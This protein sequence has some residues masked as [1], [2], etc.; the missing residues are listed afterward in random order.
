MNTSKLL[1]ASLLGLGLAL[2]CLWML[3]DP[4]PIARAA[5]YQVINTYASGT[6]SLRWAINGANSNQPVHDTITF[7][8]SVSGTIVL[9]STLPEVTD[10]LTITGPGAIT[11]AISGD[12][13]YRVFEIASGTAVTISDV[14][15]RDGHHASLGGG[16]YSEGTLFLIDTDIVSNTSDHS[17][18]GLC[19][20]AGVATL[21][22]G[23]VISNA[24]AIN[25]G[26]IRS[27]GTLLL[28]GADVVSNTAGTPSTSGFG[29]GVYVLG[30]GGAFTQTDDS[31]VGYNTADNGGGVYVFQ[32]SATLSGGQIVS[33]TAL[34]GGG[35]YVYKPSGAFTQTGASTVTLNHAYYDG[36]GMYVNQG[37]A[38][39][40]GGSII[41]NSA[42]DDGGAVY[43]D[44]GDVTLGGGQIAHNTADDLGGGVFV[45]R[46]DAVFTQTGG[47]AIAC[48][49]AQGGGGVYVYRGSAILSG[50][51]LSNTAKNGSSGGGGILNG[52]GSATLSGARVVSN[53]ALGRGGG[54]YSVSTLTLTNTTV[55]HNR[56]ATG[57]GGGIFVAGGASLSGGEV[58]NNSAGDDGGGV[59]IES[60][61]VTLNGTRVLSNTA[62]SDGGGVYNG[63]ALNVID[64][65][66]RGN[67][68]DAFQS[69]GG[70]IYNQGALTVS[71][72]AFYSNSATSEFSYGG[73][74]CN[75]SGTT[76]IVNCMFSGNYAA[77]D[78]M[79]MGGG[80]YNQGGTTVMTFTTVVSNTASG[81][82]G[83]IN[84]TS[85]AVFAKNTLVAHNDATGTTADDCGGSALNS[86]GHNLD[87]DDTCG[88]TATSDITST[89]PL[90]GPLTYDSGTWVHPLLEGS[91]A[92]N[93][94]ECVPNVTT[95]DQRGVTRPEGGKCDIGAYEWILPYKV[96][97]P[98]VLRN[99]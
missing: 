79:G 70:G 29:G 81:A 21:T 22:G 88:L 56:A 8:P 15:I 17:G 18:G 24:A 62:E 20:N 13:I 44:S 92:I 35:V 38:T 30:P 58:S 71:G 6:G 51:I 78:T 9:T 48:N 72:S 74:I 76:T 95:V 1:A 64:T 99:Y 16:I 47:A 65:L 90:L 66:F 11:L 3:N 60:G 43:V 14:T 73:G 31:T 32:G 68:T 23:Q 4:L 96:H 50:Q 33:N 82:G 77:G 45:D 40:K 37:S 10:D 91:P 61:S 86:T 67:S 57:E 80:I 59:D 83:G 55:R 46:D 93:A 28:A 89:D 26:G 87:S 94:G 34:T 12:D 97:L 84:V 41:D 49:E 5:D 25:G 53:T 39:V 42:G 36:G 52:N 75:D 98:L 69:R 19:V 85:G 63:G 7:A 2:A 54:I 27:H